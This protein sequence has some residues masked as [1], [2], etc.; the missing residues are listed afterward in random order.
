M[1]HSTI[2]SFIITILFVVLLAFV[3][4][5]SAYYSFW[6]YSCS[7]GGPG[8]DRANSIDVNWTEEGY[9]YIVAGS[10]NSFGMGQSDLWI[11]RLESTGGVMWARAI[12]GPG[13]DYAMSVADLSGEGFAVVGSTDSFGAGRFDVWVIVYSPEGGFHWNLAYGGSKG[14]YAAAVVNIADSFI[15]AGSTYSFGAGGSDAWVIKFTKGGHRPLWTYN[16]FWQKTYGGNSDDRA[17]SIAHLENEGYIVAGDTYSFGAGNSDA[18]VLKLDTTGAVT[19]QK[20]YGGPGNDWA[21]SVQQTQDGGYIVAGYTYSF[22][23]GERDVWLLKLDDTG[24]VIWQKTYGGPGDDWATSIRETTS[25]EGYL[26]S[27]VNDFS[28]R[29]NGDAFILKLDSSGSAGPCFFEG[30]STATVSDTTVTGVDTSVVASDT[31]AQITSGID[32]IEYTQTPISANQWCSF[33]GDTRKLTVGATRKKKGEGAIVS[34]EGLI[35]CPGTCREDYNKGAT[36]TLYA[37]PS[38]LSTFL[39]WKPASLG[40]EG[41]D[42]CQVMMDKKKSV[43]AVFQGPNKL[44]VGTTFKNGGTGTVIS[45]DMLIMCPGDCEELYAFDAPVTLTA[46]AGDHAVFIK[47]TGRPCKD[48]LTNVCTFEMNKNVIVKAVFERTQ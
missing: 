37:D 44:K 38:D 8:D 42:P 20:T 11:L 41:T 25:K 33:T 1:E 18:W 16:V 34:G 21:T 3:P 35:N 7:Y 2:R 4:F 39:G 22:G 46:T 31:Q 5:T 9:G 6:G 48:A 45:D 19:W 47:W 36:V 14:D 32:V 28:G 26:L 23:A 17:T 24:N 40:C 29:N 13:H 27:A 10:T 12:G 15:V 30:V 43:K